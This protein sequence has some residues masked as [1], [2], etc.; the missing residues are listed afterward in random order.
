VPDRTEES[1]VKLTGLSFTRPIPKAVRLYGQAL[2]PDILEPGDLILVCRKVPNWTSRR[3]T[4]HQ[5]KMFADE[6]ARWYHAAVSGGRFEICEATTGGVKTYEYW[7]YMTGEYDIRVRRLRDADASTRSQIAYYAA[8]NANSRY[9]FTNLLNVSAFLHSGDGWRRP[10][11]LSSG[12][13]CSQL[14]YEACMRVG[15]ILE[16]TV[17]AELVC[18]AHLSLSSLM[19]DVPLSWVPV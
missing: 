14:Y 19:D 4:A 9:G 11:I 17:R 15:Y 13:I 10:R 2:N 18:P 5:S 12:I 8:S 1:L 6:H 3:I 7:Q 16:K